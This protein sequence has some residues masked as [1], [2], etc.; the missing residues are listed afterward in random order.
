MNSTKKAK[1][2]LDLFKNAKI[3]GTGPESRL[4]SIQYT[5]N[6]QRVKQMHSH[7]TSSEFSDLSSA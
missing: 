2:L 7:A 6:V 3:P 4:L 1:C 5:Q